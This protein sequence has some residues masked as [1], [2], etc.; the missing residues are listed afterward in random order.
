MPS[1]PVSLVQCPPSPEFEP[2]GPAHRTLR[3][4]S[5]ADRRR[6]RCPARSAVGQ[7][8]AAAR[9]AG[10]FGFESLWTRPSGVPDSFHVCAAW[11]QDTSLRT[12][13]AV[14][15]AARMWTPLGL[16]AQAAT[17]AELS[18]GRFVLG[19]GAGGYRARVLGL[20]RP[21][22]PPDRGDA[23]IRH[24]GPRTAGRQHGHGRRHGDGRRRRRDARLAR[25]AALGVAELPPASVYLAA[26]G[27]Q[28]LRLRRR[29]RRRRAA[30]L[31]DA[32]AHR[33]KPGPDRRGRRPGRPPRCGPGH[34]VHPGLRR[35]RRGRGAAGP[36][37]TGARLRPGPARRPPGRRL[38]GPVPP[39]GI[40]RGA[41]RPGGP[42]GPRRDHRPSSWT[43]SR[44]RCCRRWATTAQ[45]RRPRPP[46]RLSAGLDEAIVRVVT[47]RP[48]LEPVIAVM[49]AL[50]PSLIRAA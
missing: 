22:E 16:A 15:P 34:D 17:L 47:A 50:T 20:G 49:A 39:H 4:A 33:G 37:P 38:P 40:R 46:S 27:P 10:Q 41:A 23:R 2:V 19:L 3:S 12:G 13:I 35:R 31:G 28:M 9:E 29:N 21:A 42:A 25:S 11:S 48:G 45:P 5:H 18:S 44:S 8:R 32:R 26:L 43:P 6:A 36:R 1:F 7:L 30:Q 14:V 24:P